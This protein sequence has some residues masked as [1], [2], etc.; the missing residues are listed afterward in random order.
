MVTVSTST[1]G[2]TGQ[3]CQVSGIYRCQTHSSNTI[4]LSRGETFPPCSDGGRH[5]TT[6][7]LVRRA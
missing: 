5:G 7:I 2:K 3:T 4:P 6:W 1:Q